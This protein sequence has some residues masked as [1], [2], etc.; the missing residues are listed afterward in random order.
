MGIKTIQVK[1]TYDALNE[2]ELVTGLPL[3]SYIPGT[4]MPT[5]GEDLPADRLGSFLQSEFG[6]NPKNVLVRKFAHGQSNPTYY[7]KCDGKEFVLRKKPPGKLL[8]SAHLIDREYRVMKALHGIVPVPKVLLYNETLLDTPFYLME[9]CRGR[10][11]TDVQLAG[12]SSNDRKQIYDEM[13][14]I[15]VKI[16]SVNLTQTGLDD[17]GRKGFFRM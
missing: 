6:M 7:I 14:K 17:F 8:A 12:F 1:N 13:R 9:Y 3:R 15:L 5:K 16:H 4:R 11:F 2:L 10:V